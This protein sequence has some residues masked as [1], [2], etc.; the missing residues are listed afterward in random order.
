MVAAATALNK[1]LDM[2]PN[3]HKKMIHEYTEALCDSRKQIAL[4]DKFRAELRKCVTEL[5]DG[6]QCVYMRGYKI[7]CSRVEH[8]LRLQTAIMYNERLVVH[9]TLTGFT[10]CDDVCDDVYSMMLRHKASMRIAIRK[11]V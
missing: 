2:T 11:A 4:L 6:A 7:M 3:E 10:E 5:L 8:Q 9:E 1:G